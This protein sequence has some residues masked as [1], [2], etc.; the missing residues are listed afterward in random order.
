MSKTQYYESYSFLKFVLIPENPNLKKSGKIQYKQFGRK[1]IFDA[2][3]VL[4][5]LGRDHRKIKTLA[6]FVCR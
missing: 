4:E 2:A 1:V 6:K 5:D 3:E